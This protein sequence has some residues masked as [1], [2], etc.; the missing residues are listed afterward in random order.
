MKRLLVLFI[1]FLFALLPLALIVGCQQQPSA[2]PSP[3]PVPTPAPSPA[4]IPPTPLPTPPSPAPIVWTTPGAPVTLTVDATANRATY[5]SGGT[6]VSGYFYRPPGTGP[7]P[8]LLVLHG[9]GGLQEPSR[10]YASWLA[11]Q[12][13]VAL[14]PDYFT[15][16]GMTREKFS[17]SFYKENVDQVREHLAQG[18]EA[19]KSLSYVAPNRV[20]VVGFSLGGYLAFILGT[21]DDV[22]AIVSYYGAYAPMIVA[23]YPFAD[24]VAQMKAPVLMFH[25]DADKDVPIDHANTAQNLL[26]SSGKQYEYIVYPGVGHSFETQGAPTFNARATADAQEKVLA[27]LKAKLQ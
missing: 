19:L 13:Y 18:L 11:T 23:R 1:V 3:A 15:P 17:G 10:V 6:Q 4:P 25:G 2:P 20:E 12:G 22:K 5:S 16:I 8:A 27:F 9:R 24:V 7:F 21:R 26:T 14:A